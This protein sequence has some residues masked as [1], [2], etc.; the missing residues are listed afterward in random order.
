MTM[1]N[2][3]TSRTHLAVVPLLPDSP[4]GQKRPPGVGHNKLGVP[5]RGRGQVNCQPDAM[6]VLLQ[7]H[8]G[9]SPALLDP[10]GDICHRAGQGKVHWVSAALL[11]GQAGSQGRQLG[12][13]ARTRNQLGAC[14]QDKK[15]PYPCNHP[16][17][18]QAGL[19][20]SR[21]RQPEGSCA[22][23]CKLCAG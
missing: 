13:E 3:Q 9:H 17:L 20:V 7:L 23:C 10:V 12:L 15:E 1:P 18:C 16:L 4:A 6:F 19:Q 8:L 2:V 11:Q 22:G 21:Q 14:H 5:L